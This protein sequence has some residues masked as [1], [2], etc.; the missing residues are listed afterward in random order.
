MR[1]ETAARMLVIV[2][3]VLSLSVMFGCAGREFAPKD[4]Y[5]YW[6]YPKELP[7]AD[8]AVEQ[9]RTAGKDKQC[10]NAFNAVKDAKE[11]SYQVYAACKDNEAIAMAKEATA[12]AKA[13]CPLEDVH[14]GFNKATLTAKAK[15]IL[16]RDIQV[17]KKNPDMKIRI[18]GN[19]CQHGSE[20]YNKKLSMRRAKAVKE[21]LIKEGIAA[22][23]L[24]VVAYGETK[25]LFDLKPTP[26]NKD[27]K[28]MRANRRVHLEILN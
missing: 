20:Q 28:E 19:A 27:S 13:L 24:S 16:N 12:K 17:L 10:P 9:A 11:K 3:V 5:P 21:Y 4:P 15:K 2:V 8:R 22:K 14:F 6:Y 25:P 23:R 1:V 26:A 7:E 18:E